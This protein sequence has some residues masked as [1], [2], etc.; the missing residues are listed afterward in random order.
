MQSYSEIVFTDRERAELLP[1]N[2]ETQPLAPGMVAGPTL[3]SLIS[4]GTELASGYTAEQFPSRPGYA[5]VFRVES[6]GEGVEHLRV[7]DLALAAGPH[8]SVQKH[9]AKY[10]WRLPAGLSPQDA[11]FARLMGV[12][13]TTLVTTTARP[14]AR[15]VIAG[16]GPVGYLAAQNFAACGFNVMGCDPDVT[17]RELAVKGGIAQVSARLP[18]DDPAWQ[19]KVALVIE[20][21][22]HEQAALDAINLVKKRGEVVLLG[23]PWKKRTELSAHQI[24]HAIFHRYA[25]VRSGWE[26]EL[27]GE[28]SDFRA[29]D[30]HSNIGAA[31]EWLRD[32]KVRVS[33]LYSVYDPCDC[34]EAYQS[35]LN[36]SLKGLAIVFDWTKMEV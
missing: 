36:A 12:S 16:L 1:F 19:D 5:A 25:V 9:Q 27:P 28:E 31:L 22:G 34:Q 10:V 4:A 23:T 13:M 7:G 20:C 6:V 17:R 18:L 11:T 8:C 15:V 24:S 14:P 2:V 29:G 3:A 35:L 33:G 26:W 32:G 21:A 30:I